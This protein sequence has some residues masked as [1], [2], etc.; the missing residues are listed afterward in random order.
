M[1]SLRRCGI[2]IQWIL[3]SHKEEWNNVICSNAD[4]TRYYHT[5]KSEGKKNKYH[6]L[7][8]ICGN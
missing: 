2:Y 8:L 6:V 4:G 1:I 3:L 7:T 5:S